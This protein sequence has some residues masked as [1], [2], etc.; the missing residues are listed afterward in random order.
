LIF[1][2]RRCVVVGRDNCTFEKAMAGAD[3]CT[4]IQRGADD[5]A[6]PTLYEGS[7]RMIVVDFLKKRTKMCLYC[8]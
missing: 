7:G 2:K 6:D 8:R 1:K 3:M 5:D 4:A